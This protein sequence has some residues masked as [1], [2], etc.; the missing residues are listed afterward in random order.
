[1]IVELLEE[2]DFAERPLQAVAAVSLPADLQ[3]LCEQVPL[4]AQQKHCAHFWIGWR[5]VRGNPAAAGSVRAIAGEPASKRSRLRQRRCGIERA[6]DFSRPPLR[7]TLPPRAHAR[8]A[9]RS[10]ARAGRTVPARVP[11]DRALDST[12]LCAGPHL[13]VR[14]V[15]ER[16]K[17]LFNCHHRPVLLV[18]AAPDDAVRLHT[19]APPIAASCPQ[20]VPYLA[21]K[22]VAHAIAEGDAATHEWRALSARLQKT[23]EQAH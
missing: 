8:I 10:C 20:K 3:S 23:D 7:P 4:R 6:T 12:R 15:L 14:S 18:D 1:M 17:D 22:P 9:R 11:T 21:L 16:I 19:R 5:H 2:H 13:R